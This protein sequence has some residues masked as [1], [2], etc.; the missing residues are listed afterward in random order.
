MPIF[1]CHR[2]AQT[3]QT[4]LNDPSVLQHATYLHA[5]LAASLSAVVG[6]NNFTTNLILQPLP[7]YFNRNSERNGGNVI[8]LNRVRGNAILVVS[9]V[10]ILN[11]DDAALALAQVHLKAMTRNLKQHSLE[12][13]A[14]ADLVYMNYAD[15]SQDPLGSYGP[16]NVAFMKEVA[17]QYDPTVFWQRRTPGGFKLSRVAAPKGLTR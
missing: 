9:A 12:N 4:V 11:D 5:E 15:T 3:A 8:G 7:S 1:L 6:P 14:A 17:R 13:D 10:S 16:E 2:N